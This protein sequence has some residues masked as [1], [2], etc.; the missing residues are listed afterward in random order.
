MFLPGQAA[1]VRVPVVLL[2]LPQGRQ[3]R[4]APVLDRP[5]GQVLG[6]VEQLQQ[7]QAHGHLVEPP[8]AG[9]GVGQAPHQ[10]L[11][12]VLHGGLPRHLEVQVADAPAPLAQAAQEKIPQHVVGA[13]ELQGKI[14]K[15]GQHDKVHP[16]VLHPGPLHLVGGVLVQKQ[17]LPGLQCQGRPA[18]DRVDRPAAAHV[19]DFHVVVAVGGELGKP[20]VGP[21]GNELPVGQELLAV[22][23]QGAAHLLGGI[24]L[25]LHLAPG[26]QALLLRGD[27]P[28]PLHQFFPHKLLLPVSH[29]KIAAAWPSV[30]NSSA[31]IRSTTWRWRCRA[32]SGLAVGSY[33]EGALGMPA[34]MVHSLSVMSLGSLPK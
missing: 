32:R 31:T 15:L 16:H 20:G 21:Q 26:Q 5:L 12:Q 18:V 24:P 17:Q 7:Q 3:H 25:P 6:T 27:G 9:L 33:T 10:V 19:H 30:R 34:S 2:H 8:G 1:Q 4:A 22:H 14:E 28:Q 29:P 11:H 23:G 13:G